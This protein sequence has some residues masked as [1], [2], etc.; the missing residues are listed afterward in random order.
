LAARYNSSFIGK[1]KVTLW[2]STCAIL[3][4]FG[5]DVIHEFTIALIVGLVTGTY[6]TVYIASPV[7][8]LW[9][10]RIKSRR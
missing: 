6:S 8:L 2:I 9:E 5:G 4:F 10:Q 3:S 1:K 7:V